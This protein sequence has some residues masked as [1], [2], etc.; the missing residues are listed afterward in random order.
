MFFVSGV[1]DLGERNRTIRLLSYTYDVSR[2][3]ECIGGR[4]QN[5]SCFLE[6]LL[7]EIE[8][9][10]VGGTPDRE[11]HAAT[12][13]SVIPGESVGIAADDLDRR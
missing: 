9:R 7:L 11:R 5:L 4:F 6:Q 10:F 13:M 8:R 12:A 2:N 1:A 3:L